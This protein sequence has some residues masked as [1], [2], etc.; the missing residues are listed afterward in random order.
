MYRVIELGHIVAGPTAGLILSEMGFEVIKVERPGAGDIARNLTGESAGSFPYYNRNKKSVAINV[1]VP[2]GREALRRLINSADIVIDNFSSDFLSGLGLDYGKLKESNPGLIYVSIRGY[3]RG[4]KEG[5][6]SLDYPIEID[7]GIAY[8]NGLNN[9]PMRVG[10]SL[11]DMFSASMAVIGIYDSILERERTG[12]GKAVESSL[13]SNAMFMIGQHI[14]TF[15]VNR[16]EMLP[17]N[18]AGF[19]WG[20]YDFF[21]TLDKKKIFI[22]VTTDEQWRKFC[23]VFNIDGEIF[24]RYQTNSE[25]YANRQTLIPYLSERISRLESGVLESMLDKN[26]IVYSYLRKPWELLNDQDS[27][28]YMNPVTF[29]GKEMLLPATP[30]SGKRNE[31][32]PELGENTVEVLSSLGFNDTEIKT[33]SSK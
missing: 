14:S 30:V 33:I 3:G 9:R 15:Q 21:E 4:T 23:T 18:E 12:K 20:I 1:K 7:S 11:V 25:R 28:N 27:L 2:E 22:A 8:M 29:K 31:S 5:R 13:F 17:I 10:A 16:R 32:V 26:Q 6:R 19:A 24:S